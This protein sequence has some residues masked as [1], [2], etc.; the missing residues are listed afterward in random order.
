MPYPFL[1]LA[2]VLHLI[3]HKH[4]I[5][6]CN[7]TTTPII[8]LYNGQ[9]HFIHLLPPGCECQPLEKGF[10]T[11]AKRV[12]LEEQKWHE[13]SEDCKQEFLFIPRENKI[14]L[15]TLNI[16]WLCYL[17]SGHWF[18]SHPVP[19]I[20]NITQDSLPVNLPTYSF[21]TSVS[22]PAY[23]KHQTKPSRKLYLMPQLKRDKIRYWRAIRFARHFLPLIKPHFIWSPFLS[24]LLQHFT[25]F[26]YDFFQNPRLC[27][28][29]R[30]N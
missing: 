24:T 11:S 15:H 29:L 16:S 5:I 30:S 21:T 19:V 17:H 6:L 12:T 8:S 7:S 23:I 25:V 18:A 27:I 2:K 26:N 28:I 13:T 9:I 10:S 4:P 3:H 14:F 1:S 20:L 22:F